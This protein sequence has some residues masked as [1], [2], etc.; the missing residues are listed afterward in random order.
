MHHLRSLVFCVAATYIAAIVH[1]N[2]KVLLSSKLCKQ[3]VIHSKRVLEFIR[4]R[5]AERVK[6]SIIS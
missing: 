1:G 6:E 2:M 3:N 5:Y 4:V